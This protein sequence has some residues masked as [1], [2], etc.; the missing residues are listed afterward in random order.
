MIGDK[1]KERRLELELTQLQL[2]EL[3]CIKK[4]YHKQLRKQCELSE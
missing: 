4:K 2:S 3:T 1:I